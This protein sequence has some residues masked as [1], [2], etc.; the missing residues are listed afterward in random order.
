MADCDRIP[1]EDFHRL[2][3]ITVRMRDQLDAMRK[4]YAENDVGSAETVAWFDNFQRRMEKRRKD[5]DRNDESR[6]K[7]LKSI[8][9]YIRKKREECKNAG[10]D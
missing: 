5:R 1:S 3:A 8:A 4:L 6:K 9:D 7:S 2:L 10:K